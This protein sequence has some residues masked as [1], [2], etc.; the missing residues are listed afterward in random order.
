MG[1]STVRERQMQL[2]ALAALQRIALEHPESG[3]RIVELTD[4]FGSGLGAGDEANGVWFAGKV[5]G[6]TV[7][8]EGERVMVRY[9]SV[10]VD[11][12]VFL[13]W[14]KQRL[15]EG[16]VQFYRVRELKWLGELSA[17]GFEYDVLINASGLGSMSLGDVRDSAV[18]LD[19]TYVTVVSSDFHAAYVHRGP[20]AYTYIFGRG[21]GT[22][23]LGG[24]SEPISQTP[25]P[26]GQVLED[27]SRIRDGDTID[28]RPG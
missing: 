20:G 2:D 3:A 8:E 23:V 22:A 9:D 26:R 10:V 14:M 19:R 21:D 17:L 11:P 27:V 24:V 12:A 5:P 16:G 25:K 6:Y 1:G 28:G 15:E 13:P 18:S 7:L 4:V